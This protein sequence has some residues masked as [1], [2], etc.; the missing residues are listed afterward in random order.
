MSLIAMAFIWTGSQI[1]VYIFGAIPPYIYADIGGHDRYVIFSR[2]TSQSADISRVAGFGLF[3]PI[4]LLWLEYVLLSVH[5]RIS[6]GDDML[7]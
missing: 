2:C 6:W 4:C 7:L 1:P 3:S 5:S